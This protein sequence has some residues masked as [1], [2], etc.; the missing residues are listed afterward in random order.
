MA[1]SR[2]DAS[3]HRPASSRSEAIHLVYSEDW[4]FRDEGQR[5][6]GGNQEGV[7][8]AHVEPVAEAIGDDKPWSGLW[9]VLCALQKV[10][11]WLQDCPAAATNAHG[12]GD[13]FGR[14]VALIV[15][16]GVTKDDAHSR[17]LTGHAVAGDC[18]ER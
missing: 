9:E 13:S 16:G 3:D 10:D 14:H 11:P 8:T 4:S 7:L 18:T 12:L 17:N 15:G 2:T 1:L 5:V 6:A